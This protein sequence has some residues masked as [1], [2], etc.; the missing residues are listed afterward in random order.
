MFHATLSTL[1]ANNTYKSPAPI[2]LSADVA[3]GKTM[4]RMISTNFGAAET[5][6]TKST[7]NHNLLKT[8]KLRVVR[9]NGIIIAL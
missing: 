4:N 1:K 3:R 5:F 8:S 2:N 6:K 7:R 9:P